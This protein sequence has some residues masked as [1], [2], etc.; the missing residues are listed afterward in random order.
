MKKYGLWAVAACA[1]MAMGVS[2]CGGDDGKDSG[3]DDKKV[4]EQET[5]APATNGVEKLTAKEIYEKGKTELTQAKS[6]RMQ[7]EGKDEGQAMKMDLHLD[8]AGSC[9]GSMS[10]GE[11][12]SF[13]LIKLGDKVWMKPDAAFWKTSM[14][15]EGGGEQAAKLFEGKWLYGTT[16]DDMLKSMSEVCDLKSI[17]DEAAAEKPDTTMTKGSPTT[18]DGQQVIQVK[19]KNDDGAPTTASIALTGKPY[20]VKIEETGADATTAR[21]SDFDKPVD[22]QTPAQNQTIDVAKMEQELGAGA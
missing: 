6:L 11:G 19:G 17:Q 9:R 8:T 18:V 20:L 12:G 15:A 5:K 3:K 13:E 14:G 2:G 4:T 10:M 21:F 1:A 7:S 16:S 22:T